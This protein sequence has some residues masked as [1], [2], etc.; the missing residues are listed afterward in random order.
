MCLDCSLRTTRM[1]IG[2]FI[3]LSWEVF[4]QVLGSLKNP[5]IGWVEQHTF[6]FLESVV[7][8]IGG[9]EKQES[10]HSVNRT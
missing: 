8:A 3:Q 6:G 4:T 5:Y 10:L 1:H 7:G 2:L 9:F